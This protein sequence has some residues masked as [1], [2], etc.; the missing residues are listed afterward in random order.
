M[1][2]ADCIFTTILLLNPQNNIHNFSKNFQRNK[3]H[4]EIP[5]EILNVVL[6]S[7]NHNPL[8]FFKNIPYTFLKKSRRLK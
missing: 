3:F 5:K 1:T 6:T 4:P 8:E 2:I 7:V